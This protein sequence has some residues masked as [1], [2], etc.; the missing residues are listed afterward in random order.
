MEIYLFELNHEKMNN[1]WMSSRLF[2]PMHNLCICICVYVYTLEF[3]LIS[4]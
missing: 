3:S 1:G 2:G 4:V